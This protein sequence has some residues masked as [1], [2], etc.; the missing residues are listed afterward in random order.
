MIA[1]YW[2]AGEVLDY[3]PSDNAV[4]NGEVVSLGTRIGVAGADIAKGA[5]GPLYV[6]GVFYMDKASGAVTMGAAL[7]YDVANKKITTV[8][9]TGEDSSKVD[10]IPAGYA[11][12]AAATGDATVLVKLLG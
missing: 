10:N 4:A 3:T 8:A 9:S 11:A 1:K 5:T 2:Q 6:E 12:A 7:Y